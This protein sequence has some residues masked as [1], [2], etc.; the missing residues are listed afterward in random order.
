MYPIIDG[1]YLT[2]V[3]EAQHEAKWVEPKLGE[4]P[5]QYFG[6]FRR[7]FY[8]IPTS[9]YFRSSVYDLNDIGSALSRSG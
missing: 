8:E 2:M 4:G 5:N 7:S 6:L 1:P 3:K 9:K